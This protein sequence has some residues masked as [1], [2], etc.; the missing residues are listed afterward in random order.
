MFKYTKTSSLSPPISFP[1]FDLMASKYN[2]Q[3]TQARRSHRMYS[4]KKGVPKNFKDFCFPVK[5]AK[6]LRTLILKNI[7]ERL[8]LSS[9]SL[10]DQINQI[11]S[12][13]KENKEEEAV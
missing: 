12:L 8:L 5:F 1:I 6:F 3:V 13:E 7:C 4:V 10:I 9:T 2:T 11:K